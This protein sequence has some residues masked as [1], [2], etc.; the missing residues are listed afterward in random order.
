MSE[1]ILNYYLNQDEPQQSCLLALKDIILRQDEQIS[2]S[3]KWGIPCFSYRNRMFCFLNVY[4][5]TDEPYILFVEGNLLDHPDLEKGDR[6]RMKIFKVNPDIDMPIETI[7]LLLNSAL[8]LYR[9]GIIK[10]K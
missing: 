1:A 5:K 3:I 9:N 4:K 8:D 6:L 10:T 7:E 2:E